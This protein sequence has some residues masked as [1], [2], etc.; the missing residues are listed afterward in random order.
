MIKFLCTISSNCVPGSL[1]KMEGVITTMSGQKRP[2]ASPTVSPSKKTNFVG[3][4]PLK[5]LTN[6][7]TPT[8]RP[9]RVSI[10][11]N[12][13]AGKSTLIKYFSNIPGI[14]TF[15]VSVY[16]E[17]IFSYRMCSIFISGA[18]RMVAK[19]TWAQSIGTHV[20]RYTRMA[21]SISKLR[22]IHPA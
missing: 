6:V 21:K 11:G 14:E 5:E 7:K 8:D 13:G 16:K 9:F 12:I 19:L 15:A 4:S 22:P 18:Y 1:E 17:H 2:A 20:L 3:I 10:E